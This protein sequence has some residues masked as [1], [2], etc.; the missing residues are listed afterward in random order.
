[1]QDPY[2]A[3]SEAVLGVVRAVFAGCA[4]ERLGL[5]EWFADVSTLVAGVPAPDAVP[6]HAPGCGERPPD[7]MHPDCDRQVPAA[8]DQ[9]SF[10]LTSVPPDR[11]CTGRLLRGA[12]LAERV[13]RAIREQVVQSCLRQKKGKGKH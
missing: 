9:T 11:Q 6:A 1:L 10:D 7:C 12:V 8:L 4:V 3:A 2:R 5:D 13:R